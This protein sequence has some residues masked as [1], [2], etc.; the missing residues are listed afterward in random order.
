MFKPVALCHWPCCRCHRNCLHR[1]PR[2]R[3]GRRRRRHLHRYRRHCRRLR[4]RRRSLPRTSRKSSPCPKRPSTH[5]SPR[6]RHA[7]RTRCTSTPRRL[8]P[9][10][11]PSHRT[12]SGGGERRPTTSR[13]RRK[14]PPLS[15]Q[16][17]RSPPLED[18]VRA[19]A[20]RRSDMANL[21]PFYPCPWSDG[22]EEG[23][24]REATDDR[25]ISEENNGASRLFIE[26]RSD[27]SFPTTLAE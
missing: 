17:H 16:S 5:P 15:T 14:P 25:R 9:R 4:R 8:S 19:S 23:V 20:C 7:R 11:R 26:A 10:S 13:T 12:T 1:C 27:C 6:A 3:R 22:G 24:R 18:L 2:R 21:D